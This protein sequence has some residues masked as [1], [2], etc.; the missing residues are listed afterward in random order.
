MAT[1]LKGLNNFKSRLQKLSSINSN[2][3]SEVANE[4]ARR[5]QEIAMSEYASVDGVNVYYENL[6]GG[7]SRVVADGEQVAYIEFG[8]GRVGE[9]SY[10][11]THLPQ[12]GV[13]LTGDWK[14]YY[15]SQYKRKSKSTGEEGWFHKFEGDEKARFL[16][17]QK[18][19]M[20]M[21]KTSQRL[22]TEM[23]T[24]IK[25]KLKGDGGSV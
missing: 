4:I 5:G 10:P 22:K 12:Q 7:I 17:G 9:G 2:F 6:G 16:K 21:Y 18:A 14:Y 23:V 8:T 24:I 15:P 11:D 25:N 19:G 3:T 13:P 20:Q 1:N